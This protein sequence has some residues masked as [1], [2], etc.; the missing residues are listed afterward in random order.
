LLSDRAASV[1]GDTTTVVAPLEALAQ[2]E[3][4]R[5]LHLAIAGL[6][7][8]GAVVAATPLLGIT[9]K[10]IVLACCG[11]LG[12]LS[13]GCLAWISSRAG[14][15]PSWL[16][17]AA[18][19]GAN[20][21]ISMGV[22]IVGCHSAAPIVSAMGMYVIA[23]GHSRRLA[24]IVYA[25]SAISVGAPQLLIA[26]GTMVDPGYI[27][28]TSSDP[29]MLFVA[30]VVFQVVLLGMFA[31]GRTSRTALIQ[32]MEEFDG[33]VRDVAERD[34]RL[35]EVRHDLERALRGGTGKLTGVQL[36]S[37]RLGT[38]LGRGG[39]GEV[40][41]AERVPDGQSAAVKVLN[42]DKLANQ[43]QVERFR[44]E[45]DIARSFQA[46]EIV[47]VYEVSG[48]SDIVPYLAME[49]LE[50][51][52]LAAVL[53][54]RPVLAPDEVLPLLV[55]VSAGLE[56]AHAAG[57]VHRDLKPHNVF[58]TCPL[59]V[60]P[61]WKILD[62]GVSTL[63]GSSGT[64]TQ[65]AIIGTPA[66]MAPEQAQGH[67]LDHRADLYSLAA[68]AYRALTGRA[69][70]AGNDLAAVLFKVV[71]SMPAQPSKS[72]GISQ[73]LD[74]WFALALAKSPGDRFATTSALVNG[75]KQAVAG[76]FPPHLAERASRLL[77][78]N[79]WES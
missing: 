45:M 32:A 13:C 78:T 62:F 70:F 75:F 71:Y 39:M 72:P 50:G 64:L 33:A 28:A 54:E 41:R 40:Y 15:S 43:Q 1:A 59:G 49:L 12:L 77:A 34:G 76:T 60:S 26:T 19:I 56:K 38:V 4:R 51:Q 2:T 3:K 18:H 30:A 23:S 66:Y 79:A 9:P 53:R 74:S 6:A 7:V 36:G 63:A 21:A 42:A 31:M 44:R 29:A 16:A 35:L 17:S 47:R 25:I 57:I 46:D 20:V 67:A 14:A 65:G 27:R 37:F 73:A 10:T 11:L 52:D 5:N 8:A 48:P 69:L 24:L 61:Q 68:I 22:P 58:R 55:Q